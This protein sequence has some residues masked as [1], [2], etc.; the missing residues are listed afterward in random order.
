LGF[1]IALNSAPKWQHWP[2]A[3]L[4]DGLATIEM[5]Q[6]SSTRSWTTPSGQKV[7]VVECRTKG[8]HAVNYAAAVVALPPGQAADTPEAAFDL[9]GEVRVELHQ[10]CCGDQQRKEPAYSTK[11]LTLDGR[12]AGLERRFEASGFDSKSRL[13]EGLVAERC[14]LVDRQ[15]YILVVFCDTRTPT[16]PAEFDRFL[17]S[18]KLT[19]N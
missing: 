14:Y 18:L 10:K 16:N 15:V 1:V 12:Y 9:V 7:S 11:K 6:T 2:T 13:L 3:S 17:D 8:F 19:G 4:G 5:P